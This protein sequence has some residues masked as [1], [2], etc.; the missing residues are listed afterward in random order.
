MKDGQRETGG[1]VTF[2]QVVAMLSVFGAFI[3]GAL[4]NLSLAAE[5]AFVLSAVI[6]ASI[7]W[8]LASGV[9]ALR[10]IEYNTRRETPPD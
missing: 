3:G 9:Q 7:L 10:D 4:A 6:S 8:A 1:I 5:V 2:L